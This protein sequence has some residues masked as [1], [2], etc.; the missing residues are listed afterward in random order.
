MVGSVR[1]V[2]PFLFRWRLEPGS[3]EAYAFAVSC[4]AIAFLV[5]WGLGLISDDILPLPTFYPAVLFAALIGGLYAGMLAA[6]LGGLVCWW[7][8]M[9][10]HHAFLT[11]TVGQSISLAT[12][13][14]ASIATVWG[15]DHYRKLLTRLEAEEDLRKLAVEELAHRLKNKIAT[16]QAIISSRLR[17]NPQARDAILRLLTS[18]SATDDLIMSS[19]GE[20]AY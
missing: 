18:L 2:R 1:V 3:T 19:Q 20:G 10:P 8:F 12:Y 6:T 17:D 7:A 13:L 4:V 16:I 9:V 5:R 11:L 15:A 14:V